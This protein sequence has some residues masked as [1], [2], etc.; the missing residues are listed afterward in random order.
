MTFRTKV[1]WARRI[2]LGRLVLAGVAASLW[3]GGPA[4]AMQSTTPGLPDSALHKSKGLVMIN[5]IA[6]EVG[7]P[8]A[9]GDRVSTGTDGEAIFVVGDDGFLLRPNSQVVIRDAMREMEGGGMTREMDLE[10]GRVLA[11]FGKKE[12]ALKTPHA[13]V[14]IRGTAAY[15][16]SGPDSMNMCVCYGRAVMTPVG[17][18][19]LS[20]E[21]NNHHHETPRIVRPGPNGP[22]MEKYQMANHTDEELVMLEALFGRVPPFVVKK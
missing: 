22:V 15:L 14:S 3:R 7:T 12:I 10:S 1:N 20:E 2:W 8:V 6:A 11:V 16:E 18:P 17:A 4:Q 9:L 13:N 5:G 21:V 19:Q